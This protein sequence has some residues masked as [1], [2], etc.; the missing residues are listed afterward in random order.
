M[1]RDILTL[2][3][4]VSIQTI[5][6]FLYT[7]R[8]T[9][10]STYRSIHAYRWALVRAV[11]VVAVLDDNYCAMAVMEEPEPHI[12]KMVH[13]QGAPRARHHYQLPSMSHTWTLVDPVQSMLGKCMVPDPTIPRYWRQANN[14]DWLRSAYFSVVIYRW[15]QLATKLQTA[16]ANRQPNTESQSADWIPLFYLC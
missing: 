7:H 4:G 16:S 14:H 6:G 9:F 11:A 8:N 10:Y 3:E 13:L 2:E 15:Y 12:V 1:H 5:I